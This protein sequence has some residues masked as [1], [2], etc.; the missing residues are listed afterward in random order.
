MTIHLPT[1]NTIAGL[2]G[3]SPAELTPMSGGHATH[4]YEFTN[5]PSRCVLRITPPNKDT[6]FQAMQ[7][8]LEWL[9]F[10]AECGGPAARPVRSTREN[11]IER[12]NQDDQTYMSVAF[13]KASGILAENMTLE[14]WTDELF[15]TLGHTLGLCHRIA[16]GYVPTREDFRRPEWNKLTNCFH[17]DEYMEGADTIVLNKYEQ[18]LDSIHAL[19]KDLECYGLAHL[20]LHYGNFYID[21]SQKRIT[22]LDFDDCAYGWYVMDIAMLVF[23][24]LVVYAGPNPDRFGERFL[25]NLL[26]GYRQKKSIS[27]F[28]VAQ[29]PVFLKLLEI[30]VY[31]MLYR[32]Y[33]PA[34][35]GEWSG[36]FMPGRRD[37]ILKEIPY[38]AID[39][40]VV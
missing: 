30:G 25:R 23:D 18:V 24:V 14:D 6:N 8:I 17:P 40:N 29:L 3:I 27:P 13:E 31:L 38:V 34:A 2:Y 32:S 10:L 12:V 7:S 26:E 20:D 5:G 11:L 1:L 22:L 37:R 4:V 9:A 15:K 36:K 39:F 19:P 35:P 16:Q 33:D 28:W 21:A